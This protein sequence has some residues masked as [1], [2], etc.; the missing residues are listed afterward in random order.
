MS[1]A[2]AASLVA[3]VAFLEG[4]IAELEAEVRRMRNSTPAPSPPFPMVVR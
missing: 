3:R 2:Q 1:D 4:R